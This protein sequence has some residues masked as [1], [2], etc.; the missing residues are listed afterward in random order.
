MCHFRWPWMTLSELVKYT[1]TWYIPWHEALHGLSAAAELACRCLYQK[2]LTG[3][4]YIWFTHS[5]SWLSDQSITVHFC[6][7]QL[8]WIDLFFWLDFYASFNKYS[9]YEIILFGFFVHILT[10]VCVYLVSILCF[11]F[12]CAGFYRAMR[13]HSADYAVERCLSVHM[14]VCLSVCHTSLLVPEK[15]DRFCLHMIYSFCVIII[16]SK[17][18]C[19][20]LY[21]AAVLN[22]SV[23]LAGFLCFIQ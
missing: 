22:W 11:N 17:H 20:L 3:F 1:V 14:S 8:S 18:N 5:V 15:F 6:I 23:F 21:S 2:S 10:T 7:Q 13:M 16:R 12:F 4:V 9:F 19:S